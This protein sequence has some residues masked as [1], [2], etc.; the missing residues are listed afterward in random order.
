MGSPN[1]MH[2]HMPDCQQ[3]SWA[4]MT[5]QLNVALVGKAAWVIDVLGVLFDTPSM[6][7]FT[8]RH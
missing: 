7:V 8:T 1:I 6:G 5:S 3:D 2:D 4:W